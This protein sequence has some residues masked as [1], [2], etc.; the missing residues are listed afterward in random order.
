MRKSL[1]RLEGKEKE[2]GRSQNQTLN[3]NR[4]KT[5]TR[6]KEDIR[7]IRETK[8]TLL[9]K[10]ILTKPRAS[11][12]ATS[13]EINIKEDCIPRAEGRGAREEIEEGSGD[14]L[15]QGKRPEEVIQ[16]QVTQR[17][18]GR[19]REVRAEKEGKSSGHRKEGRLKEGS[20]EEGT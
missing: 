8:Q 13:P 17:S 4:L 14:K 12:S 5:K 6:T 16:S 18:T 20:I 10:Y 15:S 19:S 2:K 1:K 9:T 7:D 11:R 3:Q